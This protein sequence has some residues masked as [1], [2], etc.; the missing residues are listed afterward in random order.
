MPT[1][2]AILL[3]YREEMLMNL[4]RVRPIINGRFL[5]KAMAEEDPYFEIPGVV[6]VL[7]VLVHPKK[8]WN[9]FST[10]DYMY[11]HRGCYLA[12]SPVEKSTCSIAVPVST[13]SDR[14]RELE[15][16]RR[17][18]LLLGKANKLLIAWIGVGCIQEIELPMD[19]YYLWKY[20]GELL[21]KTIRTTI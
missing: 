12:S 10:S 21:T 20:H 15:A 19:I 6:V 3:S 11:L 8:S 18:E 16:L 14:K 17:W 5:P 2:Y 4:P 7:A 1:V 9:S 13:I